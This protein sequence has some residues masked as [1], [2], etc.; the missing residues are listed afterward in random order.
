MQRI[1]V[2]MVLAMLAPTGG[3]SLVVFNYHRIR[4]DDPGFTTP[5][6]DGVYRQTIN[7][8]FGEHIIDDYVVDAGVGGGNINHFLVVLQR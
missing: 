7:P 1:C 2:G 8:D 6:D 4:P 3:D 5:F